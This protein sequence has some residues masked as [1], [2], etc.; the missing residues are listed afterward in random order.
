MF[1]GLVEDIGTVRTALRKRGGVLFSINAP[2]VG[3][4]LRVN[5]S[6][7][8]NGVCLTVMKRR[9]SIFETQAVEETLSKTTLDTL[10]QGSNVNL[11][12]SLRASSLLGGHFVLGHVDCV[13]RVT[14]VERKGSSDLFWISVPAKFSRLLI[15]VGSVAVNGVSLTVARLKVAQFA[16]SI[17]PHTTRKTTFKS[18]RRGDKVN[19]EFDVLGK[20]IER[21]L[22]KKRR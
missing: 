9:G 14:S 1:T 18:I 16:V 13:G 15:P 6:I 7:A 12:R 8:V 22:G 20:Y 21:L 11:E 5:D 17:I 19:I 10:Q 4:S 2:R 3:R